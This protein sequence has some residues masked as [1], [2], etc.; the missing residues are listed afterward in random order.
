MRKWLNHPET[1]LFEVRGAVAHVTFNRPQKR[2]AQSLQAL[3]ELHGAL[4]EADDL[5]EV[6]CIVLAGAGK[7]FC[8][9]ADI[10]EPQG[11]LDYDPELYRKNQTIDDD[12]WQMR[13]RGELRLRIFHLHKPVI[14]KIQGNCLAVG[15][16]IALNCD[17]LIAAHDARIGFPATRAMGSPANHMWLYHV[18]P[19]WAKRLLMTGD[20]LSGRDAAKIGL[21][22]KSVPAAKLDAEV[23]GLAERIAQL[24][25]ELLAAHK[26]I[27]NLGLELMGWDVL[28]KLAAENDARAHLSPAY[29]GFG[30]AVQEHGLK[31]ALRRRDAPFGNGMVRL[32]DD[33]D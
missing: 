18:G 32:D 22:L 2:N 27:V 9:G 17:M 21:V 14:A 23:D 19:Q 25:G 31:E 12:E 6:R 5:K 8:S 33:P 1:L 26:R 7:D 4:M 28:Q 16:D 15:T 24:D 10:G 30:A 29:A 13:R 11:V 3:T 20:S